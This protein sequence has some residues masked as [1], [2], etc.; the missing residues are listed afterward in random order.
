MVAPTTSTVTHSFSNYFFTPDSRN[1]C[2]VDSS[3]NSIPSNFYTVGGSV[4]QSCSGK[5][6]VLLKLLCIAN[7]ALIC[8]DS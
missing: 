1:P 7:H 5:L 2:C 6:I 3:L 8:F 4:C